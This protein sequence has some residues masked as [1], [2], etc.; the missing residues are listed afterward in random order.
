[1]QEDVTASSS[2]CGFC[3]EGLAS[4]VTL[5]ATGGVAHLLPDDPVCI[6]H[7][8]APGPMHKRCAMKWV[9]DH[10]AVQV[11][12]AIALAA[13]SLG[14]G[15]VRTYAPP[16][17]PV[18]LVVDED[19]DSYKLSIENE[20][21]RGCILVAAAFLD[22]VLEEMLCS[23]FLNKPAG[24]DLVRGFNGP[25]GTF[26]SRITAAFALGLIAETE[27]KQ[28]D[29]VRRIRNECAHEFTN[30]GFSDPAVKNR[31]NALPGHPVALS[32]AEDPT[33][34]RFETAVEVLLANLRYRLD[35]WSS[36]KVPPAS[37][38]WF[39]PVDDL[40]VMEISETVELEIELRDPWLMSLANRAKKD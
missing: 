5:T 4:V 6:Q 20:S 36:R 2:V 25:L 39:F 37:L 28:L 12:V 8:D 10:G 7:P 22:F 31:V 27:Q 24:D 30:L 26:S 11:K 16:D 1:M 14:Q 32:S 13:N 17:T 9:E 29:L 18:T 38:P 34:R 35:K 3:G 19:V 23:H 15:G 40:G 33:R 21:E